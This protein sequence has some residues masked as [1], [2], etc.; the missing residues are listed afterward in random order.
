MNKITQIIWIFALNLLSTTTIAQLYSDSSNVV[1][2]FK[3]TPFTE[4]GISNKYGNIQI[5]KSKVDSVKF[6][7][8]IKI[9]TNDSIN[10]ESFIE[11]VDFE[12]SQSSKNIGIS[13]IFKPHKTNFLPSIMDFQRLPVG[14]NKIDVDYIV[15]LPDYIQLKI[16]NKYGN[17]EIDE[18]RAK[19]FIELSNGDL[20][21]NKLHDEAEINLQFGN[22]KITQMQNSY[23]NLSYVTNLEIGTLNSAE[24]DSKSSTISINKA[25][26]L[27]I[28]SKRDNLFIH[29]IDNFYANL[30]FDNLIIENLNRNINLTSKHSENEIK[31]IGKDIQLF[32]IQS[33]N[34]ILKVKLKK[35]AQFNF[36]I[37]EEK[38]S[39]LFPEKKIILFQTKD[40]LKP[41]QNLHKGYLNQKN[42][43]N[44]KFILQSTKLNLAVE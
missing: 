4:V 18:H 29:S 32:Q 38:S 8:K 22:G 15:Y 39:I 43:K 17:I 20:F 33:S 34:D 16:N 41:E 30:Y 7:I 40:S 13:T 23:L 9:S 44:L 2:A 1:K 24:I 10:L 3:V 35:T 6:Q 31:T 19:L 12:V 37:V 21:C 27:K 36:D 25:V 26:T 5:V 42:G 14:E 11:N 28:A